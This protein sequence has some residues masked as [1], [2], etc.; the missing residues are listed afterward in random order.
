MTKQMEF[1]FGLF[2]GTHDT[3]TVCVTID[4]E[5]ETITRASFSFAISSNDAEGIVTL[6]GDAGTDAYCVVG[7]TFTAVSTGCTR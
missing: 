1:R 4:H 2:L 7:V 3:Y 5:N 6:A